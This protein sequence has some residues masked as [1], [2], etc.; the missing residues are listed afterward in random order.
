[1]ARL[2]AEHQA[3]AHQ[4]DHLREQ[5]AAGEPVGERAD[6]DFRKQ[7]IMTIRTLF[8]ENTLLRFLAGLLGH[9]QVELS[10]ESLL[11]LLLS[12]AARGWRQGHKSFIGSTPRAYHVATVGR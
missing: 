9:L 10:L 2:E 4:R 7:T 8:L 1:L 11:I 3:L 6:R 5:A 12:G